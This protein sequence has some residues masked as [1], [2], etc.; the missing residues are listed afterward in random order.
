MVVII[1]NISQES[2]SNFQCIILDPGTWEVLE[3]ILLCSDSILCAVEE[4]VIRKGILLQFNHW[5]RF[6]VELPISIKYMVLH[7]YTVPCMCLL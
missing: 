7:C 6:L 3:N 2:H 1:H 4:R 5:T